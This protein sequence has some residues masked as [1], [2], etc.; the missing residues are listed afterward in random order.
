MKKIIL[1]EEQ[2][3]EI[4]KAIIEEEEIKLY[5]LDRE[6]FTIKSLVTLR[7]SFYDLPIT[8]IETK[9]KEIKKALKISAKK[10]QMF[11]GEY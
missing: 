7:G 8:N 9:E 4:V 2:A 10:G 1:P 11:K 5:A 6:S 3:Q